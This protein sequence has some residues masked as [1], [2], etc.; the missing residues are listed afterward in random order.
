MDIN[1]SEHVIIIGAYSNTPEKK[2]LLLKCI[3]SCKQT[4]IDIILSSHFEELSEIYSQVDYYIYDKDNPIITY[5]EGHKFGC[6]VNFYAK[7]KDKSACWSGAMQH[8][9]AVFTL[10]RN[11]INL[12]KNLNKKYIHFMDYD[13]VID[14]ELFLK[15]MIKPLETFPLSCRLYNV[16]GEMLMKTYFFSFRIEVFYDFI[17][18]I[19]SKEEYFVRNQNP[20]LEKRFYNYYKD[21]NIAA[22]Q[23]LYPENFLNIINTCIFREIRICATI[24]KKLFVWILNEKNDVMIHTSYNNC[25]ITTQIVKGFND[26]ILIGNWIHNQKIL[27]TYDEEIIFSKILSEEFIQFFEFNKLTLISDPN[28]IIDVKFSHLDGPRIDLGKNDNNKFRYNI[29]FID[30]ITGTLFY[31][32]INSCG[33]FSVG[34]RKWYTKWKIVITDADTN[35]IVYNETLNLLNKRVNIIFDSTAL[36]DSIAWIPYVEEFRKK[37]NCIVIC[38][39][40]NKE[41]FIHTYKHIQFVDLNI[42]TTNIFATYKIGLFNE[43]GNFLAPESWRTLPLQKIATNILG[44]EYNEICPNLKFPII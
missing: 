43:S 26:F 10:M 16:Q 23:H 12:A 24:D 27:I 9:Y 7:N 37:H 14:K 11:G 20:I 3:Q 25:T 31:S 4:N 1:V 5:E 28:D 22:Y 19:I 32:S 30:A 2:D 44:L 42:P 17:N 6:Y 29:D 21:L 8:S 34:F 40:P 36:G 41:L 35:K 33:D 39:T 38:S 18:S 13:S 15:E